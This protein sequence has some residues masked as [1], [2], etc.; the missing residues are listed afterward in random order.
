[1]SCEDVNCGQDEN[2]KSVV[3]VEGREE[4]SKASCQIYLEKKKQ[5]T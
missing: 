1:M 5:L 3:C 2:I 4:V